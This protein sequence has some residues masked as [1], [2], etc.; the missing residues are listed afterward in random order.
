MPNDSR[1]G[2]FLFIQ[3]VLEAIILFPWQFALGNKDPAALLRCPPR[4]V[5][6]SKKRLCSGRVSLFRTC[7]GAP[8]DELSD[9][10]AGG[11]WTARRGPMRSIENWRQGET[12]YAA[13]AR[14]A[15]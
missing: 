6:V 7:G 12:T 9:F 10:D 3:L 4:S 8:Q 5:N 1:E 15:V 14:D 11:S 2:A 13:T